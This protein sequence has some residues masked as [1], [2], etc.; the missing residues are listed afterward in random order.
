MALITGA[1]LGL[2]VYCIINPKACFGSCPTFYSWNGNKMQLQAEG[3]SGAVAPSLEEKDIDALYFAQSQNGYLKLKMT[4][5]ALE[6]HVI[7]YADIIA[8]PKTKDGRVFCSTDG[9]FF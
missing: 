5:E 3:F 2:T 7:R 6:T 4:N 8:I 1:S 9:N